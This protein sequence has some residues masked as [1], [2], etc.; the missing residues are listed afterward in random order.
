MDRKHDAIYR[1]MSERTVRKQQQAHERNPTNSRPFKK[2]FLL[3]LQGKPKNPRRFRRGM[4]H[5]GVNGHSCWFQRRARPGS[6][7]RSRQP[8]P[9]LRGNQGTPQTLSSAQGADR[10]LLR[11]PRIQAS[12]GARCEGAPQKAP[13]DAR[14]AGEIFFKCCR[15]CKGTR[16]NFCQH[17]M[18]NNNLALL[19]THSKGKK[20][21]WQ[22]FGLKFI[23][24]E[25]RPNAFL[26]P[27]KVKGEQL[28]GM[29]GLQPRAFMFVRRHF[30]P[31]EVLQIKWILHLSTVS[32]IFKSMQQVLC[33]SIPI[34]FNSI[35]LISLTQSHSALPLVSPITL[36]RRRLI[37]NAGSSTKRGRPAPISNTWKYKSN[38]GDRERVRA[39]MDVCVK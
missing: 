5:R 19:Y 9:L 25:R 15:N 29:P 32:F 13:D 3:G 30:K 33:M 37:N 7:T 39:Y 27:M 31:I 10:V 24:C 20:G 26:M 8:P 4:R 16:T 2:P 1:K 34:Q 28:A 14:V 17:T 11:A 21:V 38:H 12:Q 18:S 35:R 23:H 36:R 22:V 6:R